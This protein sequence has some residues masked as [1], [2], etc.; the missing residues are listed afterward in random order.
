MTLHPRPLATVSA[1]AL[2]GCATA[3]PAPATLPSDREVLAHVRE[4]WSEH[5]ARMAF[6]SGRRG[7]TPVLI[8]VS[9]VECAPKG[10]NSACI[11]EVRARF[12]DGAVLT[13]SVDSEFQRGA[14][15]S[16]AK[17]IPVVVVYR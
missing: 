4:N 3:M 8:S 11:F 14:D 7:Q 1:L 15:G 2:A 17:V 13:R 10:F 6:L 16:I 12:D 9:N 5:A